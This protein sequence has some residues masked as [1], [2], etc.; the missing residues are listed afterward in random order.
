MVTCRALTNRASARCTIDTDTDAEILLSESI[1]E[2]EFAFESRPELRSSFGFGS[3]TV[4]VPT[5]SSG[6]KLPYREK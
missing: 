5:N 4:A 3:V 6:I 2:V 1:P